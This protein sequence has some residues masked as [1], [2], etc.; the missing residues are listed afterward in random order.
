MQLSWEVVG[1][2]RLGCILI[3]Y[4]R[5]RQMIMMKILMI[6]GSSMKMGTALTENNYIHL[7]SIA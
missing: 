5:G 1:A 6:S 3:Y 4:C 7:E 2:G